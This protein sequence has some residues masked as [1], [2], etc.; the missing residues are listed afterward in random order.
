M[1]LDAAICL[2]AALFALAGWRRG[3]ILE[4]G[5]ILGFVVGIALA[6]SLWFPA[7]LAL[8]QV[9]SND[10]VAAVAAFVGILVVVYLAISLLAQMVRRVVHWLWLG[11]AD[12]LGGALLGLV[13][14]AFVIEL[15][16]L[17]LP[18]I[19][20]ADL[21]RLTA[22][23]RLTPWLSGQRGLVSAALAP[24]TAQLPIIGALFG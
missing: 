13:K 9:V 19:P 1:L 17:L 18:H 16:L 21:A 11:W 5:S 15:G 10:V 4:V 22:G 6:A 3:L 8:H 14:A 12:S 7:A 2:V 23:A 24:F 20:G